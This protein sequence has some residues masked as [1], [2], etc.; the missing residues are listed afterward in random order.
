MSKALHITSGDSAV[1]LMKCAQIE[2][3]FLP[4]R[5]VLHDGPVPADLTLEQLLMQRAKFIAGMGWGEL[6][7]IDAGHDC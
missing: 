7:Q 6:S 3:R 2:G 4:W 1:S 5:D